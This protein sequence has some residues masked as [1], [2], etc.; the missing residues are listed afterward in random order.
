M[1]PT[2]TPL[3]RPRPRACRSWPQDFPVVLVVLDHQNALVHACATCFCTNTG[4]G[5][6]NVRSVPR[7][8]LQGNAP[9]ASHIPTCPLTL[10]TRSFGD[11]CSM[12]ASLIGHSGSSTFRLSSH[13]HILGS[14]SRYAYS[15][16]RTY[17]P[18]DALLP[19][20][21]HLL[22]TPIAGKRRQDKA[23]PAGVWVGGGSTGGA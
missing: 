12:S 8:G 3:R 18:P 22:K 21:E 9:S 20:Y 15:P 6:E 11:V 4:S 2:P 19:A 7:L 23:W 5:T 13:A 1:L 16:A 17:T 10:Q 14:A